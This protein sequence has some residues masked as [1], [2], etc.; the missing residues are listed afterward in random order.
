MYLKKANA[1][2]VSSTE[3]PAISIDISS[4]EEDGGSKHDQETQALTGIETANASAN[5]Q[6]ALS[7]IPTANGTK[8][9]ELSFTELLNSTRPGPASQKKRRLEVVEEAQSKTTNGQQQL[10]PKPKKF[11]KEVFAKKS[12]L[13]FADI[14]GMDKALKEL[15]E[16]ILHIKH[17]EMYKHIG[18][19]PPRGFL[20]HG[21]P[22]TGEKNY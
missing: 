11:K 22:G 1:N 7:I 9:N 14:G 2:P 6:P 12:S 3:N 10:A 4:D 16:L 13:T 18:L 15:C 20:L 19:P 17:P 5:K 21:A 8:Q